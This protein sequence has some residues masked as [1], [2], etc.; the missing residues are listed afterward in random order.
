MDGDGAA[1]KHTRLAD[2]LVARAA[3][4]RSGLVLPCQPLPSTACEIGGHFHASVAADPAYPW[5]TTSGG[6]AHSP[7]L[8]ATVAV[9]EALERYAAAT[10]SFEVRPLAELSGH[11]VLPLTEFAQFSVAQQA[12]PEYPWPAMHS[13]LM[14]QVFRLTDH[15]PAWVPQELIGLG[16]RQGEACLASVS[17]GLAAHGDAI[18]ALWSGLFEVIERDALAACWLHALQP[19]ERLPPAEAQREVGQ[20]RGELR[21]FDLTPQWSPFSVIAVAGTMPRNG[22][23]R[24]AFGVACRATAA[25]AFDKAWREWMQGIVFA[26]HLDGK[27]PVSG[28]PSTFEQHAVYYTQHPEAWEQVPMWNHPPRSP[29]PLTD[30]PLSEALGL[31]SLAPGPRLAH[32]AEWLASQGVRL[33]YRDLTPCDVAQT[34]LHVVRVLSPDLSQLHGDERWPYLGGRLHDTAWRYPGMTRE[35]QAFPNPFPHPL[36]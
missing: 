16:P 28:L 35:T 19:P 4:L 13:G 25:E 29:T 2:A 8:A 31:P 24:A 3:T 21:V 7:A 20:R 15:A 9:A 5:Q 36:G 10:L 34:G 32:A 26:D 23:R 12:D 30:A 11:T 33:Y 17:T 27:G 22:R 6:M 18:S 14:G 1:L